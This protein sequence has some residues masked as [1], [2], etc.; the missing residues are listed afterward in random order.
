M[1]N[2]YGLI[3]EKLGHSLSPKIHG[4][5][6]DILK[7]DATY[8]LFE[9]KRGNL[10][11]AVEGMK[12]MGCRGVNVTIPYKIEI[13][14]C[15]DEISYEAQKIGAV[16]TVAFSKEGLTGHNTDYFGFGFT[17]KRAGIDVAGKKAVILGT[18]GA[19][20]AV[21]VYLLDKGISEVIFVSRDPK[22]AESRIKGQTIIAYEELKGLVNKD[23]IINSTPCG[24]YPNM[25]ISP[26][27]KEAVSKFST[28][29]DLIYNP[30]ETLFL[31][32]SREAGLKTANGLYMLVAQ[33]A[34]A[35]E[36]WQEIKFSDEFIEELY[37]KVKVDI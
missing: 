37:N 7:I 35:Q 32:H 26:V 29:V 34:A 20:K 13:M 19:A 17:L 23:I 12:A 33:A 36:I 14:D 6:F 3:G 16:N 8:S 28:A 2:F 11:T 18:G 31:K 5:I 1:S 4:C 21:L 30:I 24:M 9:I 25:D 27:D 10:K 15:I 22:E